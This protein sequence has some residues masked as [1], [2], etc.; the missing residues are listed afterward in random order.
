VANGKK[1]KRRREL[2]FLKHPTCYLCGGLNPPTTVDHVPPQ[3]CFPSG[4]APE[5]FEFPACYPCN[6]SSRV[7]DKIFGFW[8]IA[9]DFDSSKMSSGDDR[10]RLIQL[11][12]EI[13]M[14]ARTI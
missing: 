11:G 12:K 1:R 9:L 14:N 13:A 4:Y 3:A 2:F 6:Q 7:E 8:A 5:G 10:E